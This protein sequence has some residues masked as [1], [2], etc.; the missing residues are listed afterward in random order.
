MSRT[1]GVGQSFC[2]PDIGSSSSRGVTYANKW[3]NAVIDDT[4]SKKISGRVCVRVGDNDHRSAVTL[5]DIGALLRRR[6]RN[7][8]RIGL[9]RTFRAVQRLRPKAE[10]FAVEDG[11]CHFGRRTGCTQRE[12]S[13]L[14]GIGSKD[15]QEPLGGPN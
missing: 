2:R 12:F 7:V 9:A 3:T 4:G 14:H 11:S 13:G 15:L 8:A 10:L 5:S 1:K 6:D